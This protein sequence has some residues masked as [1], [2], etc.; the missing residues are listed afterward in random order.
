MTIVGTCQN[1]E[2]SYFRLTSA[3]DPADVRPEDVLQKTLKLMSGKWKRK[4]ADYRFNTQYIYEFNS[5]I[6]SM[7]KMESVSK[8]NG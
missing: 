6:F 1:L 5:Y 4:E 2:K 3:P 7:V 8:T